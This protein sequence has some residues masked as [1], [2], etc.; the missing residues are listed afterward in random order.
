MKAAKHHA[1]RSFVRSFVQDEELT[2]V[3][4][5]SFVVLVVF[6]DFIIIAKMA[7]WLAGWLAFV[8]TAIRK[9]S[10]FRYNK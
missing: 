5:S 4:F 8:S 1:Q 9:Q 3:Y 6:G 10:I 2:K 7:G